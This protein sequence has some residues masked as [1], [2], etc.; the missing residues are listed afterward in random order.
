MARDA[1]AKAE[2]GADV[3][4]RFPMP[5]NGGLPQ[6]LY[7]KTAREMVEQCKKEITSIRAKCKKDK[8]IE[9]V[10]GERHHTGWIYEPEAAA[11][12]DAWKRRIEEIERATT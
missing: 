1:D 2:A 4:G 11:A 9:L 5:R 8:R 12:V 10:G 3:L 6:P 7:P